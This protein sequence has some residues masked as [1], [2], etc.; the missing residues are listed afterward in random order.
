M[1]MSGERPHTSDRLVLIAVENQNP[2][3]FRVSLRVSTLSTRSRP[4]QSKKT[5]PGKWDCTGN[6]I[7]PMPLP[8]FALFY[9]Y[10]FLPLLS[11]EN[12]RIQFLE[13]E[14]FD[15]SELAS[16]S[17]LDASGAAEASLRL[18]VFLMTNTLEVGGSERQFAM[19]VESLS[20]D[21]FKVYPA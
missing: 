15:L 1:A 13:K 12:A 10:R 5:E 7:K 2:H 4:A 19:L 6:T 16:E 11:R 14:T 21:R 8:D 17:R 18:R 9:N 20:R 3:E